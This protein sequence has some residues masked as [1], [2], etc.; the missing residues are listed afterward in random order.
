MARERNDGPRSDI[1]G[2]GIIVS[3]D[4]Y[5]QYLNIFLHFSLIYKYTHTYV[6]IHIHI[7]I[8]HG[9]LGLYEGVMNAG[10]FRGSGEPNRR[11]SAA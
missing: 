2:M 10:I 3:I 7:E 1:V 8:H 11:L 4:K 6:Q 9:Q 5:E